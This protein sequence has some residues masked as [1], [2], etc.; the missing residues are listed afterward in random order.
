M[1]Q[2]IYKQDIIFYGLTYYVWCAD[3]LDEMQSVFIVPDMT[4]KQKMS[5]GNEEA[6][7]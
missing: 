4:N 5:T 7:R 2:Y 1:C 6:T 3:T